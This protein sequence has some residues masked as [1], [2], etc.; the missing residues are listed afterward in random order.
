MATI[1]TRA[2]K[3]SPLT[4]DEVDANFTNLNTDKAETDGATLTNVDINSGT[5]D[6]TTIGGAS[7]GAGTFTTLSSNSLSTGPITV[8]ATALANRGDI[9]VSRG[10]SGVYPV[11]IS[12]LDTNGTRG[13]R[14][15]ASLNNINYFAASNGTTNYSGAAAHNFY[16]SG[17]LR[18]RLDGATGDLSLYEDTG[19]TPKLFWDASTERLG[20][21]TTSP[22]VALHVVGNILVPGTSGTIYGNSTAGSRSYIV[23]YN[24]SN[25]DM[26]LASTFSTAS[27]KF[28]TGSTPTER[29][30][31]DSSGN[32]G[33]GNTSSGYVLT[34][35]EK[36]LTVGDGAEHSAIQLYS[37]TGKWGGL[38]FSD[39]TANE[40]GQGFIG[41]YHP[42]NYMQFNTNGTER[43]RITS[44]GN[45][46]VG[47]TTT[48]VWDASAGSA[49]DN[50]ISLLDS[51]TLGVSSYQATA[52]SGFAAAINRT[53]TDGN[54]VIFRKNGTTVGSIGV[55]NSNNLYISGSVSSHAGVQFG[56]NSVAPMVTGSGVTDTVDL[57]STTDR[58][59]DLYLSGSVYLGGTT[60]ANALD[61]YEEGTW[62]P[63][64]N[65]TTLGTVTY[66]LQTGYYVKI[67]RVVY[68]W[69]KVTWSNISSVGSGNNYI[70]GLP[71]SAGTGQANGWLN[72]GGS[73]GVATNPV[74][75]GLFYNQTVYLRKSANILADSNIGEDYNNS[76]TFG[77]NGMYNIL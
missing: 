76:G 45:L 14:I 6:G 48:S 3:G 74:L 37:G 44:S 23:M 71:F 4:N 46:L 60:S 75:A 77:F 9:E 30:R 8:A 2:G 64:L 1:T 17:V 25:G 49:A 26:S 69:G 63:V 58:W 72:F 33:I 11:G 15:A 47:T 61:D 40:A 56:T 24:V 27:I 7:A 16:S 10:S 41:Y 51:G 34:S 73:S 29:L 43:L 68:V 67:G 31:I 59:Q 70:S 50:G 57:G 42:D 65:R 19:T 38:A 21:G 62:T 55:I 18:M 52:V 53:G 32:V 66:T 28:L 13:A 35:G 54:L 5:I 20:I 22:A 36:R 39:D 12:M